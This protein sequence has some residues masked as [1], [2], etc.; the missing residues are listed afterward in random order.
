MLSFEKGKALILKVSGIVVFSLQSHLCKALVFT[1]CIFNFRKHGLENISGFDIFLP[2]M[3]SSPK[4]REAKY[5][6][7]SD[8]ATEMPYRR[9]GFYVCLFSWLSEF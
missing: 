5:R 1:L 4:V 8:Q 2:S 6:A 9:L 7:V 3:T